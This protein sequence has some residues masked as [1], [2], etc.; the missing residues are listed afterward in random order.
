MKVAIGS[1]HRG[2]KLKEYLKEKLQNKL[3]ILDVGTY[4]ED[5]VDYPD[6]AF[7]VGNL[8]ARGEVNF[9]ILICYTGIGMSIAAN[10]VKGIRAALVTDE[11]FAKLS[12]MH[13]NANIICLQGGF[14]KPEDALKFVELFLSTEFE[15]G[16][17]QRR[18]RKIQDYEGSEEV[19]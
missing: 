10:K 4:G 9:G 14:V 7:K 18:V 13:N 2:F 3:Q 17:H 19:A 8:V 15:G 5:A 12:R 6:F 11:N 16:R 1:D